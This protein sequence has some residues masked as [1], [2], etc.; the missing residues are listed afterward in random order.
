FLRLG[1][2]REQT[3]ANRRHFF[4]AAAQ[5][6][7]RILVEN[8]RR[9]GREKHGGGRQREHADLDRFLAGAPAEELAALHEALEQ[10]TAHDPQRARLVELLG[11][12]G[13]TL[14][15]AALCLDTSRSTAVRAWRYA[16]AWLANAMAGGDPEKS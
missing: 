5:A 3:F 8:A 6:M 9:K 15:E 2:D 13:L 16:R 10:F 7:R 11:C 12:G 14:D 1:G 4:A